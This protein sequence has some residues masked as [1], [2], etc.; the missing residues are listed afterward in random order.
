MALHFG[1]NAPAVVV[2]DAAARPSYWDC[3]RL[4]ATALSANF[5]AFRILHSD[6]LATATSGS[7]H[8]HHQL[9]AGPQVF[10]WAS[11]SF[12]T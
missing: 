2:A 9:D 1:S 12:C 8:L 7:R 6:R 5:L 10:V 4:A 3:I 11:Q